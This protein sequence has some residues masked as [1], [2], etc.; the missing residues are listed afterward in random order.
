MY[1]LNQNPEQQVRKQIANSA[2][3]RNHC[4]VQLKKQIILTADPTNTD[5]TTLAAF[6]EMVGID[7]QDR[8]SKKKAGS[9]RYTTEQV[10]WVGRIKNYIA[11]FFH[12]NPGDFWKSILETSKT[13]FKKLWQLCS[14]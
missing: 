2:S 12:D 5:R 14:Q 3:R 7:F 1:T 10:K 13:V 9:T 8:I 4:Y 6:D 11:N